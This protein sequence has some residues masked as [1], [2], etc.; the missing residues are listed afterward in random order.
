[1]TLTSGLATYFV[2]WWVTL[3]AVLPWRVKTQE[4]SGKV[5]PGTVPSAP[6][7]PMLGKKLAATTLVA[8]IIFALLYLTITNEWV[9]LDD[10]P[11]GPEFK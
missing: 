6:E 2:I 7:K 11:F 10:F 5:E 9:S 8:S 1:M 4:E 3:F